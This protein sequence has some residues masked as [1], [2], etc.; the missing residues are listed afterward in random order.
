MLIARTDRGDLVLDNQVGSIDLWSDTPYKFIKRQS[1]A[2][3]G[4]WV[5]MLDNRDVVVSTASTN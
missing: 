4:E 1:Q 2:D 3:A 5:D